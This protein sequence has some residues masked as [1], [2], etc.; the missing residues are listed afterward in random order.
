MK[1]NNLKKMILFL[2]LFITLIYFY[3]GLLIVILITI[4]SMV[5]F[6]SNLLIGI[7]PFSKDLHIIR[8]LSLLIIIIIIYNSTNI[9]YISTALLLPIS[10]D[11]VTFFDEI[12][13]YGINLKPKTYILNSSNDI[14]N[15]I[16]KFLDNLDSDE[17]FLVTVEFTTR[18]ALFLDVDTPIITLSKAILLN[19]NSNATII[20]EFL[21]NRIELMLDIYFNLDDSILGDQDTDA[22][23]LLSYNSITK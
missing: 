2:L 18:F 16:Q 14:E 23:I 13:P 22:V 3:Y 15:E 7:Y 4:L 20:K 9:L 10:I 6:F 5:F 17:N 11:K 19:K 8:I 12:G 21:E 1:I